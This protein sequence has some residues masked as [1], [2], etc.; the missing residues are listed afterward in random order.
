VG[1]HDRTRASGGGP[2][3]A[4]L[5]VA[6]AAPV[7]LTG[8]AV[9]ASAGQVIQE[10]D[11]VK[12]C[13]GLFQAGGAS[14]TLEQ[15]LAY[16]LTVTGDAC[17]NPWEDSD[18]DG[19]F[20][21]YYDAASP[22]HPVTAFVEKGEPHA[23]TAGDPTFYAFLV[24]KGLKDVPDNSGSM[25]LIFTS[26]GRV[27]ELLE[28]DA[29]FNCLG[30][31]DFG[32]VKNIDVPPDSLCTL[33]LSAGDA[34]TNGTPDGAYEGVLIFTRDLNRP[35]HPE[36]LELE[37]GDEFEFEVHATSWVYMFFVD[38]SYSEIGNNLGTVTVRMDYVPGTPVERASW[39]SIKAPY[40]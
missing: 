28:V 9:Q 8:F 36:I 31:E 15:G 38:E 11:A 34:A 10:V 6:V 17:S 1:R 3:A 16:E 22:D 4:T 21:F 29:V 7:A 23:F 35:V 14:V 2:L 39:T 12:N 40:R 20:V 19:V 25:V 30:L 27:R 26:G 33:S 13:V 18:Y 5:L 32:A 37:Y 24:D